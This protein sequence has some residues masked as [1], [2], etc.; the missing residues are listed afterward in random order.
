MPCRSLLTIALAL[1]LAACASPLSLKPGTSIEE[2]RSTLGRP[3]AEAE[4]AGRR[5]AAAVFGPAQ[6]PVRGERGLRRAGPAASR[7]GDDDRRELRA[8]AG[9]QGHAGG[10]AARLRAAG[11]HVSLPA[12]ERDGVHVPLLH[13]RRVQGGDVHLLRSGRRG[14]ANGDRPGSVVDRRR[15]SQTTDGRSPARRSARWGTP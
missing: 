7:R 4:A 9:G 11:G 6:Q 10:R 3:T 15:R 8:R 14:E 2:A 13:A 5:H 12:V 1:L